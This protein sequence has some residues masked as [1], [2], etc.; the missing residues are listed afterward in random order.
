MQRIQTLYLLAITA[1]MAIFLSSTLATFGN[2]DGLFSLSVF[3]VK[4]HDGTIVFSTLYLIIMTLLAAVLPFVNIFLFK[5]RMLQIRLCFVEI[6]LLFGTL[7]IAGLYFYLSHRSL[8]PSA[9]SIR[10]VVALPLV[11]IFFAYKAFKATLKDELLIKS[12]DRIR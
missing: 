10:I 11:S 3:G 8:A 7:L 12:L 1:L 6:I 9:P 2:S 4:A 5:K